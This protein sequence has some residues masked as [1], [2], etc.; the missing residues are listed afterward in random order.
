M[1]GP[2]PHKLFSFAEL[3]AIYGPLWVRCDTCRRFR[4]LRL[5][6]KIRDRDWRFTRFSCTRCGGAGY[7]ALDRPN[8]EPG[9]ED[10][11]ED[12]SPKSPV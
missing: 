9:R 4:G 5:T 11:V 12:A 1:A 2:N 6:P 3:R 8:S 7:C 10:Y